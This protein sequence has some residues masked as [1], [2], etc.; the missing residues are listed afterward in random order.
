MSL[1]HGRAGP[2]ANVS[3]EGASCNAIIFKCAGF[4]LGALAKTWLTGSGP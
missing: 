2:K 3:K 1:K 4:S